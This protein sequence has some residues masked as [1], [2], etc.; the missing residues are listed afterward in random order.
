MEHLQWQS[1]REE[2]TLKKWGVSEPHGLSRV[3]RGQVKI[4]LG[5]KHPHAPL[6]VTTKTTFAHSSTCWE[7]KWEAQ[8]TNCTSSRST[9]PSQVSSIS[10]LPARSS[11]TECKF[12]VCLQKVKSFFTPVSVA[13]SGHWKKT[14][15]WP[16]FVLPWFSSLLSSSVYKYKLQAGLGL[17]KLGG[18]SPLL[19]WMS[20]RQKYHSSKNKTTLLKGRNFSNPSFLITYKASIQSCFTHL[21]TLQN[22]K[23]HNSNSQS[24]LQW[25]VR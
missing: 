23:L 16:G 2:V 11:F 13:N 3:L 25:Q 20:V 7:C 6:A 21:H 8:V 5:T 14:H 9:K 10:C 17:V 1:P 12:C 4:S 19:L 18:T 24:I 15:T 22:R